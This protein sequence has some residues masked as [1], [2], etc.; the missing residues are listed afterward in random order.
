MARV[1]ER[2][3][4]GFKTCGRPRI[5]DSASWSDDTVLTDDCPHYLESQ[6]CELIEETVAWSFR[7]LGADAVAGL[8][9]DKIER[10]TTHLRP[11]DGDRSCAACRFPESNFSLQPRARYLSR[12]EQSQDE[13]RRRSLRGEQRDERALTIEERQAAALEALAA[14]GAENGRVAALEAELAEVKA[15]LARQ[16]K[17]KAKAPAA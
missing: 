5:V 12:S 14:Q 1:T 11:A 8:D 2:P 4:A 9:V 15:V 6:P 10:S 7:D 17:A 13:L 16:S 3:V